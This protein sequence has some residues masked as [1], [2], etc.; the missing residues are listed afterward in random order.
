MMKAIFKTEDANKLIIRDADSNEASLI[1]S[2]LNKIKE[3]APLDTTAIYNGNYEVNGLLLSLGSIEEPVEQE[4]DTHIQIRAE[5]T[6][7]KS[8]LPLFKIELKQAYGDNYL[9]YKVDF[10]KWE[11]VKTILEGLGLQNASI[12][13]DGVITAENTSEVTV[14][15]ATILIPKGLIQYLNKVDSTTT[16]Y[17]DDLV[18]SIKDTVDSVIVPT[19]SDED[20]KDPANPDI[21]DPSDNPDSNDCN[22]GMDNCTC[23]KV[24]CPRCGSLVFESDIKPEDYITVPDKDKDT[25]VTELED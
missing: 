15:A 17:N 23:K 9:A 11:S 16:N 3:G 10:E 24:K 6:N 13:S 4:T 12:T 22:C 19:E 25:P 18:I 21:K 5:V 2:F 20:I 8:D 14:P 7:N 1:I